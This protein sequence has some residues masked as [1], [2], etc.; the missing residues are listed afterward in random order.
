[1]NK[2]LAFE[3]RKQLECVIIPFWLRLKDSEYGGF[4]GKVGFDLTCYKKAPKCLVQTSRILWF[5]SEASLLLHRKDCRK[6]ADHAYQFIDNHGFDQHMGGLYWSL[7]F[8]GEAEDKTKSSFNFSYGIVALS[9]YYRLTGN[10]KALE[11]AFQLYTL[12]ESHFAD[13]YGYEE[14]LQDDFTAISYKD[15]RF[16]KGEITGERTMNT[17]LH[18][19]EAYQA[20]Y[21]IAPEQKLQDKITRI[22]SLFVTHVYDPSRKALAIYFDR[23]MNPTSDYRSFGHEIEASW[24]LSRCSEKFLQDSELPTIAATL[25]Q[26]AYRNAFK[27]NSLMD[28]LHTPEKLDRRVHWVQAEAVMGFFSAYQASPSLIEYRDAAQS[29]WNFIMEYM[30]DTRP[31]SE[32]LYMVDASG[33]ITEPYDIV[34]SWKSP[35]NNGRICMELIKR[36]A[37]DA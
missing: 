24:M 7:S 25:V 3:A 4:Y 22:C 12:L 21:K 20:L 17:L 31:H 10:K 34:W 23:Y 5:F 32:W 11:Q 6:A 15:L 1:M 27:G 9:A 18:L 33:T 35:Y 13:E 37:I 28:E 19:L 16:S 14:V 2:Q 30:V 8:N 26:E 29:I 36:F